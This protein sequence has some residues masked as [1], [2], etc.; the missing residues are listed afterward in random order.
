MLAMENR[1]APRS[2]PREA[3]VCNVTL[4]LTK[5]RPKLG[6]FINLVCMEKGEGC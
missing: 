5:A 4:D 1:T 2:A 6:L 3:A